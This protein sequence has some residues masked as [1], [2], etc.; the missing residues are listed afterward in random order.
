MTTAAMEPELSVVVGGSTG[1]GAAV[2]AAERAAG[3]QVV[4]WDRAGDPDIRCDVADPAQ[5]RSAGVQTGQ[6]FGV[7][8][9]VTICA[10]VGHSG[11]LI[12][13]E[14]DEWD[15]VMNINA[16]GTWLAMRELAAAMISAE[17]TGSIVT[18]SSVSARL[19]D[20]TM[21]I[22]CASKAAVSMLVHVAAAEWAATG[23]RVNAVAP[24]VTETPMLGGAPSRGGWLSGV[25]SR[26]PLGRLGTAQD[27]AEA[28]LALHGAGWV[29][30]QILEADGGLGLH[31]PILAWLPPDER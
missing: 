3:R 4:V 23:I 27:I 26:T 7:P 10:G 12:G 31:S 13:A 5:V 18:T 9:R 11:S 25:A 28:V 19:A 2:V 30:G 20:P 1:I 15:R 24:G 29:T 6:R 8:T 16:R 14:P 17:V 22:Y 21:G